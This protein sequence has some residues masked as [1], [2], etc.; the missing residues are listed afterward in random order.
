MTPAEIL[1]ELKRLQKIADVDLENVPPIVRPG[2][3]GAKREALEQIDEAKNKYKKSIRD[4]AIV[5][6]LHGD[7]QKQVAF[8]DLASH[9]AETVT[10]DCHA[11][12]DNMAKELYVLADAK[13]AFPPSL[14]T[15]VVSAL[16]T[17]VKGC[18]IRSIPGFDLGDKTEFK[19]EQ[20]LSEALRAAIR[21]S[22]DDEVN[23]MVLEAR[24]GD[25]AL[26]NAYAGAAIGVCLLNATVEEAGRLSN[27]LCAGN[28]AVVEIPSNQ[29]ITDE[30]VINTLKSVHQKIKSKR[31]Q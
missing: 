18:G 14:M 16:R 9:L 30:Y 7:S 19:S 6:I 17:Q 22:S 24:L 2:V 13:G 26:E 20:E 31:K 23:K 11:L 4:A 25:K 29:T 15:D 1:K 8:A 12:Y 21:A 3:E 5:V 28:N 27:T 10:L